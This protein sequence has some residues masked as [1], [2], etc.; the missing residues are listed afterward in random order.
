MMVLD[1]GKVRAV[2]YGAA[3]PIAPCSVA[4]DHAA[5]GTLA[6]PLLALVPLP[7]VDLALI[8]G[9]AVRGEG[10]WRLV[11]RSAD[12]KLY[13]GEAVPVRA[14]TPLPPGAEAV[15]PHEEARRLVDSLDGLDG[16]YR[17]GH[18]VRSAGEECPHGVELVPAGALATPGVVGLAASVGYDRL[19]I[20]PR[21]RVAVVVAGDDLVNVGLPG[22]GRQRD[23]VGPLLANQV[24][25]LGATPVGPLDI[26][27][28]AGRL[29]RAVAETPAEV[30]LACGAAETL[31]KI[32]RKLGAEILVSEVACT[33]ARNQVLATLPNGR[34]V[35]GLAADACQA[36]A[37]AVT[38]LPP[39]LAGLLGRPLPELERAR[40][41]G[42]VRA[43]ATDTRL[44][45]VQRR[46][47]AVRPLDGATP[48]A[49]AAQAGALAAI[50]P[51]WLGDAV[52]LLPL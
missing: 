5:G 52:P 9:Y 8:G 39:V 19:T 27:D 50:P 28:L 17:P 7:P 6:E 2:A 22:A 46:P 33:P 10:P 20:R 29:Q 35:V 14:G 25:R 45:P 36:L 1:W 32:L 41:A 21:P 16:P 30:V 43:D 24:S 18:G 11:E 4:F 31:P 51:R 47:E 26:P 49:A 12:R 23:G 37:G 44:I 3:R 40:L 42:R 38:M 15:L 13:T 34:P 48:L